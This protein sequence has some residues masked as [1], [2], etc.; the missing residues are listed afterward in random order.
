MDRLYE[1][2]NLRRSLVMLT[3][4]VPNALSREKAIALV[5]ELQVAERRLRR[6]REG[7]ERLL[8]EDRGP[9]G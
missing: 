8:G 7:L 1:L 3:P 2:E 5:E 6:L 4:N 9:M